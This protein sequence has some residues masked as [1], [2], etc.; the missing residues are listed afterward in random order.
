SVAPAVAAA[1]PPPP[2]PAPWSL[3]DDAP[4]APAASHSAATPPPLPDFSHLSLRSLQP[5]PPARPL[6][7]NGA[8]G[9]ALV[10]AGSGGPH[11]G[12]RLLGAL[13]VGFEGRVLV[14]LRL[15]GGRYDNLVKQMA[16]VSP[17]PVGLAMPGDL[18]APGSGYVLQDGVG[19]E[20]SAGALR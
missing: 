1:V 14:V 15:A 3:A 16:R 7:G 20:P 8:H 19:V 5:Q 18:V 17:V 9:A 4:V 13:R 12:R 10:L 2:R 11:R 6:A